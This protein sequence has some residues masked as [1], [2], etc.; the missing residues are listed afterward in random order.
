VQVVEV[1]GSDDKGPSNVQVV[2]VGGSGDD[3]SIE[4]LMSIAKVKTPAKLKEL[5]ITVA[6]YQKS[7]KNALAVE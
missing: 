2:E 5:I 3:V 6:E 1:G 4:E 7:Q